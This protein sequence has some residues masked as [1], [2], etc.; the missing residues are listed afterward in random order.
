MFGLDLFDAAWIIV[1][2]ILGIIGLFILGYATR[3]RFDDE[4]M[5]IAFLIILCAAFWPIVLALGVA[6]GIISLPILLGKHSGKINEFFKRR[7]QKK[8]E[9]LNRIED[10]LKKLK[11]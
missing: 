10:E 2:V 6:V 7:K 3:D 5:M 4:D 9:E 1:A 8:Q 11:G